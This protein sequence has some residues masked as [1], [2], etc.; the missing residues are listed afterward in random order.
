[1]VL[2]WF[3]LLVSGSDL[4]IV[5]YFLWWLYLS[6]EDTI[7]FNRMLNV[8]FQIQDNNIHVGKTK[9]NC[10]FMVFNAT[11]NNISVIS[12]G[13]FYWWRKPEYTEKTTNLSQVTDRFYL[14][15]LYRVHLTMSWIRN[16]NFSDERH[17]CM[18]GQ[19]HV[20]V[21]LTTIRSP[22]QQRLPLLKGLGTCTL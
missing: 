20:V 15:K 21:H 3:N 19:V 4:Y 10:R 18:I 13:Q 14:I 12:Y 6:K 22:P 17:W 2:T 8:T 1:M 11:F 9:F 5:L 7:D 16:N